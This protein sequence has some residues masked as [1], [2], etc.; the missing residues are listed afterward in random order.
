M[1]T[2]TTTMMVMMAAHRLGIG[3]R[4]IALMLLVLLCL[5]LLVCR[6]GAGQAAWRRLARK[7]GVAGGCFL[8]GRRRLWGEWYVLKRKKYGM[9]LVVG[10]GVRDEGSGEVASDSVGWKYYRE[11][12]VGL[13]GLTVGRDLLS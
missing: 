2:R 3:R 12:D 9:T 7:K 4:E 6:G 5:S 11:D 13:F 1:M 10:R 8:S